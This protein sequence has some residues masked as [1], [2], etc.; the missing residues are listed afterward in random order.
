[1]PALMLFF[2]ALGVQF[3]ARRAW[4][5]AVI[6][7]LLAEVVIGMLLLTVLADALLFL[8][9]GFQ[10]FLV[11]FHAEPESCPMAVLAVCCPL[12]MFGSFFGIAQAVF[13]SA[14]TVRKR[15]GDHFMLCLFFLPHIRAKKFAAIA[16]HMAGRRGIIQI[17][18]LPAPIA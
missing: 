14:A 3:P 17:H 4:Y 7:P 8:R 9:V 12:D 6:H 1:M 15:T 16:D 11:I 2:A 13:L 10:Q 18:I 5:Q